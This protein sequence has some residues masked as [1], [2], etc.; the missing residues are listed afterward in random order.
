MHASVIPIPKPGKDHPNPSNYRPI[1]LLS[2]I[3]K[4]FERII[5]KCLGC[6]ISTGNILPDHQFGFRVAHST[7][8][9]LRRVV[10]HVKAKRSLRVPESTG[11]LF[12]D[13]EK[14]FDSVWHE[15]LL[16]KILANGWDIFL[17]QHF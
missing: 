8:H 3:S 4:V 14:A 9:L 13:V 6:F 7:S 5:L 1:S 15:A 16:H 17:A 11:I 12:L 2:S 10:R